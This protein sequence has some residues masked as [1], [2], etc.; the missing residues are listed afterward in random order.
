MDGGT[1]LRGDRKAF[2]VHQG[3]TRGVPQLVAEVLVALGAIQVE[4]DVAAVRGQRGEGEAQGIGAEGG[5][6]VREFL[7]RGFF[8][9]LGHLWLHQ[10]G[11]TLG[12]QV[13]ERDAV[14]DVDRVEDVA[15]R[16]RHLLAVLVAHEAGDVDVLEGD[17]TG[18]MVGHHDHPGDPEEDDV[19]A[20]HQHRRRQALVEIARGHLGFVRPAQGAVRPQGRGEPGLQDV[21]V[22]GQCCV[23]GEAVLGAHFGFIAADIGIAGGVVPGRDAMTPPELARDAPV[24]DVAE[25]MPVGIDPVFR[26]EAHVARLPISTFDQIETALREA[27]H[28][29]EPLVGQI[30]LDDLAG[31]VAARHLQLVLLLF[32]QQAGGVQVGKHGL[33]CGVAIQAA[34]LRRRVFVH[35]RIR[36]EDVDH[37]QRMALADGVVVEIVRRRDFHDAGAEFAIDVIVGDD[38]DL[39]IA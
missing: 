17:A 18:E 28:L 11:R 32:H 9:L 2:A 3:E 15:L 5:N 21:V 39:A 14:D 38:R 6:A 30:G 20:G 37:R 25:P 7:A 13:V 10:A 1:V 35:R 31:A 19:E 24:L 33:A 4:L 8:D 23:V 36:S 22:A 27:V 26:H 34:I 12:D 16:L 29:H